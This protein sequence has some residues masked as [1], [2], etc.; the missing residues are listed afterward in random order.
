[1]SQELELKLLIEPQQR[2]AAL[3][4]CQTIASGRI[5]VVSQLANTY[6]DTDD[7]RL[8]QFDIGLRIRRDNDQLEQTVKLAGRVIGGMHSRPEYNLPMVENKPDL[9][10]FKEDIWPPDFPLFDVQRQLNA[11]FTTDFTR[12][13]WQ[14]PS[15]DG[16]IE[17]VFDEGEVIAGEQRQPLCEIELE[18]QGGS[19]EQAFQLARQLIKKVGA[20]IGVLSKAARGY[21]LAQKSILEPFT[22]AHFVAVKTDDNVASGLYRALEYALKHW[23]HNDACLQEHSTVRAAS[24]VADGMRLCKVVLQQ[25]ANLDIDV[26]DL[27]LKLERVQNHFSWLKRYDGLAELIAEDGAY[28]RSL[29]RQS[30]LFES[31]QQ[32][33]QHELQLTQVNQV[34]RQADY[35]LVLLNL[36]WLLQQQPQTEAMQEALSGWATNLLRDDWQ[37]V[38]TLVER[39]EELRAE[40]Y[41]KLLPTLQHS[42]QLGVCFGQLFDSELRDEFRAPWLDMVRGIRE[43]SALNILRDEIK[44]QAEHHQNDSEQIDKLLNWQEEQLESLMYALERSRRAALKREAY[45][46]N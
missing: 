39:D 32:A 16:Q 26:S 3:Q 40:H 8:R 6:Y 9:T 21:L 30:E 18:L 2:E 34:R 28:H 12:H 41:L 35:Q 46:F 4:L 38:L 27:L 37:R 22:Q 31:L 10:L 24:G 25:L 20:R 19:L 23:Q 29:K 45:W 13:C 36:A 5:P 43:I 33:Q 7:L 14:L 1:M 11:I 15:A 42:L 44:A 17:L